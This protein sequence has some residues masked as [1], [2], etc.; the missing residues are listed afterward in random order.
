[1]RQLL[2]KNLI[3]FVLDKNLR[4]NF[5]KFNLLSDL[6]Q[7]STY[8]ILLICPIKMHAFIINF[9][10][11]NLDYEAD[12]LKHVQKMMQVSYW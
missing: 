1:M 12:W 3:V 4:F 9:I 6:D 7:T 5:S 11:A 10:L 2:F 8:V